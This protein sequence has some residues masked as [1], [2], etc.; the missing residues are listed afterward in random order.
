MEESSSSNQK[1]VI[2]SEDMHNQT[3][4][5]SHMSNKELASNNLADLKTE[6]EIDSEDVHNTPAP[7]SN[8]ENAKS[9]YQL[10][11]PEDVKQVDN[12]SDAEFLKQLNEQIN[13]EVLLPGQ[14]TENN[15]IDENIEKIKKFEPLVDELQTKEDQLPMQSLVSHV[16]ADPQQTVDDDPT[17]TPQ[18]IDLDVGNDD[19]PT[20]LTISNQAKSD[21]PGFE[22][23]T[24]AKR[25]L[26]LEDSVYEQE[27]VIME[28]SGDDFDLV[29]AFFAIP[30]D[31]LKGNNDLFTSLLGKFQEFEKSR[32]NNE[33]LKINFEQL[34]YANK[35]K[36]E[37]AKSELSKAN[38]ITENLYKKQSELIQSKSELET[39]LDST[40]IIN[41]KNSKIMD[42]MRLKISE[43]ESSKSS[44]S[45][46]LE[47]KQS[48]LNDLNAEIKVLINE[49]KDIR[50]LNLE[51]ETSKESINAELMK[52][53]FEASRLEREIKLLSE[54]RDWF[55]NELK[56]KVSELDTVRS[57]KS[58]EITA[59][60]IELNKEKQNY[61]IVKSSLDNH[62]AQLQDLSAKNHE[63]QLEIKQL[64]D[65]LQAQENQ[66]METINKRDEYIQVLEKT[67]KSKAQRIESL[68]KLIVE[69]TEKVSQDEKD[70]SKQF[71]ELEAQIISKDV[72]IENLE[73]TISDL[74]NTPSQL[75]IGEGIHVSSLA[76][77]TLKDMNTE[78]SLTDLISELNK[79]RK[80]VLNEKRAK[81]KAE[82]ELSFVLTEMQR[83]LPL[84]EVYKDKCQ[85]YENKEKKLKVML[86]NMTIDKKNLT[87]NCDV[88][89]KKIYESK[90]QLTNLNKYKVDLQRQVAVLLTELQY[91]ISGES[92]LTLEEK[93]YIT[94]IVNSYGE[95]EDADTTDTDRLITD[96]L[97]TFKNTIEL[98]KQNEKLLTVSRQLGESL[99]SNEGNNVN[100]IDNVEN[101]TIQKSKEAIKKLQEEVKNLQTRLQSAIH[102]KE[103]LQNIIDTRS[104]TVNDKDVSRNNERMEILVE[105]LK[106]K[107][108]ELSN[109]RK[110][111]DDKIFELQSKIQIISSEKSD[112]TLELAKEK[113]SNNLTSEK[114]SSL[115]SNV[116]LYKAENEK[117]RSIVDK[118][119]TNLGNLE[120]SFQSV[121][122]KLISYNAKIVNYEVK[123]KGLSAE[124]E[125]WKSSEEHLRS[126]INKLYDEK[127]SSNTMIVRLQ[128]LDA[129]R[130]AHFKETMQRFSNNSELLQKE[131]ESLREK[132]EKAN[133]E[134]SGI[135]HSKNV[136][137]KVYQQ[138]IDLLNE[139][140][141]SIKATLTS[142]ETALSELTKELEELKKR[143]L[144]ID[145]RKQT[146]LSSISNSSTSEDVITLKEELARALEE[147]ELE[148]KNAA[149]YKELSIA[150]EQQL[151]VLNETYDQYKTVAED[152]IS[153]LTKE[154][155]SLNLKIS[156]L[157][158]ETTHLKE[159]SRS[160]KHSSELAKQEYSSKLEELNSSITTFE[161][162]KDDYENQ[163]AIVKSDLEK[164]NS[165]ITELQ[166]LLKDK[167]N[168]IST[169]EAI[170][171]IFKKETSEY[172]TTIASM[173]TKITEAGTL[174]E[175]EIEANKSIITNFEQQ[176]RNDKIRIS[177]LETQNRTLINQLEEAPLNF[178]ESD[179]MKN[180]ITYLNREKDSLS[181]QLDYAKG[182]ESI[183]RQSVHMSE[184]EI[185]ALKAELITLKEKAN[186]VE[187][188]SK[189]I[190]NMKG[191]V[192]ELK[193][194]KENNNILREQVKMYENRIHEMESNLSNVSNQV[195]P[196][197]NEVSSLKSN[198]EER[199]KLITEL[200][201]EV[202]NMKSENIEK[203]TEVVSDAL[204][205]KEKQI[206]DLQTKY[207]ERSQQIEKLKNQF[208][209]KIIKMRGEKQ[210][211]I[212]S[213]A[214]LK[215]KME[216]MEN[217]SVEQ[218]D[219]NNIGNPAEIE[220]FQ[221][222]IKQLNEKLQQTVTENSEMI[223]KKTEVIRKLDDQI[224]SLKSE[225]ASATANQNEDTT[226]LEQKYKKEKEEALKKLELELK[227][228]GATDMTKEEIEAYKNILKADLET[229]KNKIRAP[230]LA[231]INEIAE[232]RTKARNE[233]LEKS[234]AE[235]V[236]ELEDKYKNNSTP[237]N[238]NFAQEKEELVKKFE[239]DKEQLKKD[240][241]TAVEKEKEFKE[242]FL[243]NKLSRLEEELKKLKNQGTPKSLTPAVST[244]FNPNI[245][246]FSN[247]PNLAG[248]PN[249]NNIAFM[250][251]MFNQNSNPGVNSFTNNKTQNSFSKIA[252]QNN[253]LPANPQK[254]SND[255]TNDPD[256]RPKM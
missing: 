64:S 138:R 86:D 12:Q 158:T 122:D 239:A 247:M 76:Q 46:L 52:Y 147:L 75:D 72:K 66:Y 101:S 28:N 29:A 207:N 81:L 181:Q 26:Q 63:Y 182:E 204:I 42:D 37:Q 51:I 100:F 198:I 60:T 9:V 123:I 166:E 44:I 233:E 140:V 56:G 117:L 48:Q 192:E 197:N 124:K 215:S 224:A 82:N 227:A 219:N 14:P 163:L 149:Q 49:N 208:N 246:T 220:H 206:Q 161:A 223:K 24:P 95:I 55:E 170:N 88:L 23:E 205:E 173:E 54:S 184:K 242:K 145:E 168:E 203:S 179:D 167:T 162:I 16:Q 195:E 250:P 113:S 194:Y 235:K 188:Y 89:K 50:K 143:H 159:E 119:Q 229:Y 222:Q 142:K 38:S 87:K 199:E 202:E 32:S 196:L 226:V 57:E 150:T 7:T 13:T 62:S 248:M 120:K 34:Q 231:K 256:K 209:E 187:K 31:L 83:K 1:E 241:R 183:L 77:K 137:S 193:V 164:K 19:N 254:R 151:S 41:K 144:S 132:L 186:T 71:E 221:Q 43:L 244:N 114:L 67:N 200:K 135:L 11:V 255:G 211:A 228:N 210:E 94:D 27:D 139:Q 20:D 92:P 36:I 111:Y 40:L 126:E 172:K 99:E 249:F 59:L 216:E 152:K 107:K 58:C 69:T 97:S 180:L 141:V 236:K 70:Y 185:D 90:L 165:E 118:S 68:D 15:E 110:S 108:E 21:L 238:N 96:R 253:S 129:E 73:K 30:I 121:S 91:K 171:E 22:E 237:E 10:D 251:P 245:G 218:P 252:N 25:D 8:S 155:D 234:Y 191:E 85:S 133:N 189:D 230:S 175:K 214:E 156:E 232:R 157:E 105:E 102:S 243:Q 112:V 6:N 53:K 18:Q 79:L 93:K 4:E 35:K 217:K 78:L 80:D 178:G 131:T 39:S 33:I 2:A 134:I 109:I 174:L 115:Q 146:I 84:M 103:M 177:E 240:I 190:A 5:H 127:A 98:I 160:L 212:N 130:Q 125:I 148:V 3:E 74:S 47:N 225:I 154:V 116:Q 45:E 201:S 61:E 153:S 213:L 169:L 176:V 136:D 65:K 128:T 17:E 106:L 104:S